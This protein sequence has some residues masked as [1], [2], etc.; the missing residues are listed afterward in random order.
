MGEK[1]GKLSFRRQELWRKANQDLDCLWKI[2][3]KEEEVGVLW[4]GGGWEGG[5]V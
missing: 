5:F 2:G 4:G 3:S 1:G